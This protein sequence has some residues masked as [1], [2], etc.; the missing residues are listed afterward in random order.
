MPECSA[1]EHNEPPAPAG[2]DPDLDLLRVRTG[3]DEKVQRVARLVADRS[4]A[5]G[6]DAD[7]AGDPPASLAVNSTFPLFSPSA[8]EAGSSDADGAERDADGLLSHCQVLPGIDLGLMRADH[9]PGV[10]PMQQVPAAADLW[11]SAYLLVNGDYAR[12]AGFN[13][14][15][16]AKPVSI[17]GVNETVREA[18]AFCALSV[19]A[20][21]RTVRGVKAYVVE[22][23][24]YGCMAGYP[25]LQSLGLSLDLNLKMF[26]APSNTNS[27]P[28]P[29]AGGSAATAAAAAA[30]PFVFLDA[31]SGEVAQDAGSRPVSPD[32]VCN[33]THVS[34]VRVDRGP[35]S[36]LA[37]PASVQAKP[38]APSVVAASAPAA[39]EPAVREDAQRKAVEPLVSAPVPALAPGVA[40]RPAVQRP[41]PKRAAAEPEEAPRDRGPPGRASHDEEAPKRRSFE[42]HLAEVEVPLTRK[43]RRRFKRLFEK[44]A[45]LFDGNTKGLFRLSDVVLELRPGAKPVA[46]APY[47]LASE[48]R[49]AINHKVNR[50]R[51]LGHAE[52]S[53][54]PWGFP[55][56]VVPKVDNPEPGNPDHWRL[57]INYQLLNTMLVPDPFVPPPP[58]VLLDRLAG[59]LV[60]S[61]FDWRLAYNQAWIAADCRD[62]T[63]FVCELGCFRSTVLSLG[64]SVAPAKFA[65]M[66]AEIVGPESGLE[67]LAGAFA[68]FF[69]DL[70]AADSDVDS[71]LAKLELL[72]S[73]LLYHNV[74]LS[75]K[76]ERWLRLSVEALGRVVSAAGVSPAPPMLATLVGGPRPSSVAELES[77]LGLA[78]FFYRFVPAAAH[79]A[80]R[81]R[82]AIGHDKANKRRL[83]WTD[84]ASSA[85]DELRQRLS[86]ASALAPVRPDVPFVLF[87]DASSIGLGAVLTQDGAVVEYASAA[88]HTD[89]AFSRLS[90][91]E[92]EAS[93]VLFG[94]RAFARHVRGRHVVCVVDSQNLIAA[95]TKCPG[96]D[97]R[98]AR[99]VAA[100]AE[101][102]PEFRLVSSADNVADL[103]SRVAGTL[104]CG[105]SHPAVELPTEMLPPGGLPLDLP[106]TADARAGADVAAP[107]LVAS[108]TDIV[109]AA[110]SARAQAP[111]GAAQARL[112]LNGAEQVDEPLALLPEEIQ[113]LVMSM[114]KP[115]ADVDPLAGAA[116][117]L[118][119]AQRRDE[120][121]V[122]ILLALEAAR[123]A[124]GADPVLPAHVLAHEA[125]LGRIDTLRTEVALEC[126][127]VRPED[128]V[129]VV[130]PH[131][132]EAPIGSPAR[133]GRAVVPAALTPVVL[134]DLHGN[135]HRGV[136]AVLANGAPV[137]YWPR[138]FSDVEEFVTGC[139][140]CVSTRSKRQ[141]RAG[142]LSGTALNASRPGG[143]PG[144]T[145]HVDTVSFT[146]DGGASHV[147]VATCAATG[148][149]A[150]KAVAAPS[151][152]E[153]VPFLRD[154]V[155]DAW[156]V[157][158]LATDLGP[159]FD[160]KALRAVC[161]ERGVRLASSAA[162]HAEGNGLAERRVQ[163]V[164][165]AVAALLAD[166]PD[167]S[168]AAAIP[169]IRNELNASI[170][171]LSAFSPFTLWTGRPVRPPPRAA[172]AP[173]EYSLSGAALPMTTVRLIRE[174]VAS[175]RRDAARK[176]A[177]HFNASRYLVQF[178]V[179]DVVLCYVGDRVAK[180]A[181]RFCGP[182]RVSAVVRDGTYEIEAI[183]RSRMPLRRKRRRVVHVSRMLRYDGS[184][185]DAILRRGEAAV[186]GDVAAGPSPPPAVEAPES[187]D[188]YDADSIVGFS[189]HRSGG[190]RFRVRWSGYGPDADTDEPYENV[191]DT[192][193]FKAWLEQRLVEDR[194]R[195]RVS[196]AAVSSASSRASGQ[197]RSGRRR[198]RSRA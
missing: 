20:C 110:G 187:S 105:S 115:A 104:A 76:K 67:D 132:A 17:S 30:Q 113:A 180:H 41:D 96:G 56:F 198:P 128:G 106:A 196:K 102:A 88:L 168:W 112:D 98:Y 10:R 120:F 103:L 139:P 189:V 125:V 3:T 108:A 119:E 7:A 39:V 61:A 23:L 169:A 154:D 70:F 167:A 152:A 146:P 83:R 191:F 141:R 89:S 116:L 69:D 121:C 100:V 8:P 4:K 28:H 11:C 166:N 55:V 85:F 186:A 90:I 53:T 134:A 38:A 21:G 44:A 138:F 75:A 174:W 48:E 15:P 135:T 118:R 97:P 122:A 173:S 157:E 194:G 123:A 65:R 84:D 111:A 52:K 59:W 93:A 107:V 36:V 109:A 184:K 193:V 35:A 57:V 185:R 175:A 43:Q 31:Q 140:V 161:E 162:G 149:V 129:L 95:M 192:E 114:H 14:R 148:M 73:R 147:V 25:L 137:W 9:E 62:M 66:V 130:E 12:G 155:V 177:A 82:A 13:I 77:W 158:H 151:A 46:L 91:R 27:D 131:A 127:R 163:I 47:K 172:R 156:Q 144:H 2:A 18:R 171:H 99:W 124:A 145:V 42:E 170:Q 79:L 16:L 32:V 64:L 24:R 26:F 133:A 6:A 164:R 142:L 19:S 71:H 178:S 80:A 143:A 60:Y 51:R 197:N 5:A 94:L 117:E 160:N 72:I 81:V 182:F 87:T 86:E 34:P 176:S 33:R 150:L 1:V 68:A 63:T 179:G 29:R 190:I 153:V 22:G 126:F 159:E 136:D 37:R 101:F 183:S 58:D 92:L 195:E 181:E 50:L 40:G 49:M 78:V 188:V 165:N 45:P 54:A 74:Q